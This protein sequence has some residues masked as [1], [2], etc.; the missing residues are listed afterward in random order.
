M[1]LTGHSVR[2]ARRYIEQ[3]PRPRPGRC[4]PYGALDWLACP[5]P[6]AVGEHGRLNVSARRRPF[7]VSSG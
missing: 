6:A 1:L 4:Y 2:P 3:K 7:D 5:F